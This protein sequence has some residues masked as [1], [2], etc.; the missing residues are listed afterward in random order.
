[1]TAPVKGSVL[2]SAHSARKNHYP[3][4]SSLGHSELTLRKHYLGLCAKVEAEKFWK[5]LPGKAKG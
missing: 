3:V 1:L 4:R 2:C 5:I